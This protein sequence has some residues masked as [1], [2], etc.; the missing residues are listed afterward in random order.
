MNKYQLLITKNE[1]S[2]IK[3]FSSHYKL[4]DKLIKFYDDSLLDMYDHNLYR[5]QIEL[6]SDDISLAIKDSKNHNY[7]YIKFESFIKQ[8]LLIDMG[9]EEEIEIA[10][11]HVGKFEFDINDA[12]EIKL[13]SKN[14]FSDEMMDLEQRHYGE[15]YGRDF[16]SRKMNRYFSKVS[17]VGLDFIGAFIKNKLVGYAHIYNDGHSIGLD[18]LLVD[19]EYRHQKIATTI[20]A[21]A[22]NSNNVP[23]YLHADKEDTPI[24]L[25]KKLGFK[26]VNTKYYYF[27][28]I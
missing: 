15:I 5:C 3:L 7:D 1:D 16:T 13:F 23:L 18:G 10:L 28:R 8:S 24:N 12:V 19:K 9:F 20:L 17:K 2:L 14:D 6:T 21:F 22:I 26:P 25:Y 4:G 27:K 11:I